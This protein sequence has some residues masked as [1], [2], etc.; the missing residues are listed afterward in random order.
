M[1]LDLNKVTILPRA[2]Q[3][4]RSNAE[5]FNN[6]LNEFKYFCV[7]LIYEKELEA[8]Y[9]QEVIIEKA[10]NPDNEFL[11]SCILH[12]S[13]I[14]QKRLYTS[15]YKKEPD[16]INNSHVNVV[17]YTEIYNKDFELKDFDVNLLEQKDRFEISDMLKHMTEKTFGDTV[18][19]RRVGKIVKGL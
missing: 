2:M 9:I 1:E 14:N 18:G 19:S 4:F 11:S 6:N 16:K 10:T 17:S 5:R 3:L 12:F 15:I 8:G 7:K 13:G